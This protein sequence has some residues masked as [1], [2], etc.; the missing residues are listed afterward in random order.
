MNISFIE[1]INWNIFFQFFKYLFSFV[2]IIALT[3]LLSPSEF[4]ILA[5][6]SAF[7][8]IPQLIGSFALD[9]AI[10][11]EKNINSTDL[12]SIFWLLEIVGISFF[13]IFY[14]L[15]NYIALFYSEPQVESIIKFLSIIFLIQPL[16]VVQRALLIK[17]LDFKS[18][19][20]IE[21][22]TIVSAGII[23]IIMARYNFGIWALVSQIILISIFSCIL[24]WIQCDWRPKILFN[25]YSLKKYSNFS[26]NL[27]GTSIL[28]YLTRFLDKI[29]IGRNFDSLSLGY[30]NRGSN[31]IFRVDT[32][33]KSIS[34]VLFPIYSSIQNENK[35]ILNIHLSTIKIILL[36]TLPI[37]AVIILTS[38]E[39]VIV[40]FGEQWL[41]MVI[42]LK[43]FSVYGLAR[44]IGSIN[45]N[46]YL[47]KGRT[48]L[49][50]KVNI[51]TRLFII[52]GMIVGLK[53]GPV[54][55]ALLSSL[56]STISLF[57]NI[58]YAGKLI[59][60]SLGAFFHSI[61]PEICCASFT[62]LIYILISKLDFINLY[63]V[64]LQLFINILIFLLLYLVI[65]MLLSPKS[66]LEIQ[67]LIKNK[68][69]AVFK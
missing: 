60:L 9:S 57:P 24:Y 14:F 4:G 13:I 56:A 65:V 5:M 3:R 68:K 19:G 36:I 40:L 47:S 48:D 25:Y 54:G 33:G 53:W 64:S 15:S 27:L 6:C 45:A 7:I 23:A 55:V 30:Y 46:L 35:R 38:T 69:L 34:Q 52:G 66:F 20:K 51:F 17:G 49:Q 50:F 62:S 31:L 32:L 43:I 28:N 1:S 16:Y 67:K 8:A 18:I 26:L 61:L 41:N 2:I 63:N 21:N 59:D 22:I 44:T 37:Y 29:I 12:S 39:L 11:Q 58:Y 10:I 42:F